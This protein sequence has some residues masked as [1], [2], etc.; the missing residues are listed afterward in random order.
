MQS[1]AIIIQTVDGVYYLY[2][3][4][5]SLIISQAGPAS[6]LKDAISLFSIS[7]S[8]YSSV[9]RAML[10]AF[11]LAGACFIVEETNQTMRAHL[12]AP[13]ETSW[14]SNVGPVW[15]ILVTKQMT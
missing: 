10:V 15:P 1:V 3:L 9:E 7:V 8:I 14:E 13:R 4:S 2:L 5:L 12:G 6:P 11:K